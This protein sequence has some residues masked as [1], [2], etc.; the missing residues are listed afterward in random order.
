MSDLSS[1]G[2]SADNNDADADQNAALLAHYEAR[3]KSKEVEDPEAGNGVDAGTGDEGSTATEDG[4]GTGDE[5]STS[6]TGSQVGE[7]G[8]TSSGTPQTPPNAPGGDT[9][10]ATSTDDEPT[11]VGTQAQVE[12]ETQTPTEIEWQGQKLDDAAMSELI[13]LRQ[14]R[15]SLTPQAGQAINAVLAET[16][17][18]VPREVAQRWAQAEQAQQAPTPGASPVTPA[19]TQT[20]INTPPPG[21][22]TID[23]DAMEPE[24]AAAIRAQEAATQAQI[25][26]MQQQVAQ[27]QQANQQVVQQ[28]L[29]AQQQQQWQLVEQARNEFATEVGVDGPRVQTLLQ[30]V[31]EMQMLPRL[32]QQHGGDVGKATKAALEQVAWMDPEMRGQMAVKAGLV[33]TG[34][35]AK[36][37]QRKTK[38]AALSGGGGSVERPTVGGNG[39]K[40]PVK[41]TR[42][43]AMAAEI[44]AAQNDGAPS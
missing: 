38:A 23:Y 13:E 44:A 43:Q 9:G 6:D 36:V 30:Q 16:H 2:I 35:A 1:L 20:P 14:W 5:A 10:G 40:A 7:E 37:E 22:P 28:A 42:T 19:S 39:T 24:V 41:M 25:Q 29:S 27:I 15:D 33:A 3:E 12:D 18:V 17:V 21:T 34:E 11:E 26:A 31:A 8:G 32:I 4:A